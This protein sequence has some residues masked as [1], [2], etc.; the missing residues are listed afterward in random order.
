M[1]RLS[2]AGYWVI[3]NVGERMML[4]NDEV[5]V[6]SWC[7]LCQLDLCTGYGSLKIQRVVDWTQRDAPA[8]E[9]RSALR[10]FLQTAAV[11]YS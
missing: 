11:I 4:V 5:F 1:L 3:N 2:V 6:S 9:E 8:A 7:D 10:T